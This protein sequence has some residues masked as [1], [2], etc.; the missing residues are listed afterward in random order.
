M[1][2]T[3]G[4]AS[5]AATV[6]TGAALCLAAPGT[7]HAEDPCQL[8]WSNVGPRSCVMNEVRTA[9]VLSVGNGICA[10]I[11]NVA[12]TAFDGPLTS[13]SVAPGATHSIALIVS[14]GFSP[15]GNWA[16]TLLACDVNLVID[17]K[18]LDNGATGSLT[19][20]IPAGNT[21]TYPIQDVVVNTGPGRVSIAARTDKPNLPQTAEVFVP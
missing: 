11:L 3:K 9:P 15:L 19:R 12:G 21:S 6:L 17:W 10:S 4:F 18:N 20:F 7:A 8:G 1:T 13:P 2:F 16:P 5:A 14:Q